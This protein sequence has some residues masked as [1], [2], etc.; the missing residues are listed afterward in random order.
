[1]NLNL[2]LNINYY[3]HGLAVIALCQVIP[4][5]HKEIDNV[6]LSLLFY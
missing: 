6:Y 4:V 1:M 5:G 3:Q 2:K